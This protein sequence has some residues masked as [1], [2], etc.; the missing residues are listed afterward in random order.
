M[1]RILATKANGEL[2]QH[3]T[4]WVV[5]H[6]RLKEIADTKKTDA[7]KEVE[8][9]RAEDIE[10]WLRVSMPA[11]RGPFAGQPWVKYVLRELSRLSCN[12]LAC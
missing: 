4:R 6:E 9:Q 3:T 2:S 7:K 5:N 11:L 12:A 10:K 1:A 8:K